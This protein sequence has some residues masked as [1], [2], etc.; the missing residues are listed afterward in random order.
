[1]IRGLEK[2]RPEGPPSW[3]LQLPAV[4][5]RAAEVG[6]DMLLLP[7]PPS[8]T[9]PYEYGLILALVPNLQ[10]HSTHHLSRGRL[11]RL[12][13]R[14]WPCRIGDLTN[15]GAVAREVRLYSEVESID[16]IALLWIGTARRRYPR[17]TRSEFLILFERCLLR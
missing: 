2:D 16:R 15:R 12:A 14:Q 17:A 11:P 5:R 10:L 7:K 1:M 3:W 13:S 9:L 6:A 4:A 8:K